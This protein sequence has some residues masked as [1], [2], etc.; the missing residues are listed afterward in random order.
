MNTSTKSIGIVTGTKEQAKKDAES[1]K[2]IKP[3][4]QKYVIDEQRKSAGKA[5]VEKAKDDALLLGRQDVLDQ[6]QKLAALALVG[7][8]IWQQVPPVLPMV[9][10]TRGSGTPQL[11]REMN[12][13][14]AGFAVYLA[15]EYNNF[16]KGRSMKRGYLNPMDE[17]NIMFFWNKFNA[18]IKMLVDAEMKRIKAG[19]K[20]SWISIGD[21][22]KPQHPDIIL[23]NGE[24]MSN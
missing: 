18:D 13:D 10:T 3:H 24:K 21:P 15:R 4:L 11:I 23:P 9:W 1:V 20:S 2:K 8:K 22:S 12:A 17:K 16:L 5:A 7:R 14:V 6:A 19:N